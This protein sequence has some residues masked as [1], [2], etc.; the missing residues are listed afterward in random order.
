VYR[1]DLRKG[2]ELL[3]IDEINYYDFKLTID[4]VR[5]AEL[6]VFVDD[7]NEL[8]FLKCKY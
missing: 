6:I 3:S 7:D 4:E 1:K 2:R 8:S 5:F